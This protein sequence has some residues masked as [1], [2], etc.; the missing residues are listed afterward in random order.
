MNFAFC[1]K[2]FVPG[3]DAEHLNDKDTVD[4][5]REN[6]CEKCLLLYRKYAN[7]MIDYYTEEATQIMAALAAVRGDS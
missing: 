3:M 7:N 1:S 4:F 5:V 2:T 6:Y